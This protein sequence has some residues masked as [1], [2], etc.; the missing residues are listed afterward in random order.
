MERVGM[1][2]SSKLQKWVDQ[3]LISPK[4]AE[5]IVYLLYLSRIPV[6]KRKAL[7]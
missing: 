5:K 1:K 6:N 2:I 3:G 7:I 4:Q